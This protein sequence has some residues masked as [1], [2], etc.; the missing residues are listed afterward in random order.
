MR[1]RVSRVGEDDRRATD[2]PERDIR[3]V[4]EPYRPRQYRRLSDTA[5]R[6]AGNV[7][8]RALSAT[9]YRQQRNQRQTSRVRWSPHGPSALREITLVLWRVAADHLPARLLSDVNV[10]S[11][12]NARIVV[13]RTCRHPVQL[14]LSTQHRHRAATFLTECRP[15]SIGHLK[16]RYLLRSSKPP[17]T[18]RRGDDDGIRVAAGNLSALEAMAMTDIAVP[19]SNF[20]SNST[21]EA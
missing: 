9:G 13:Q 15:P 16:C 12:W 18:P 7:L 10:L 21:T 17:E 20:V 2:P 19:A 3:T 14:A 5:S 11:H 6:V 4:S 8:G 1:S